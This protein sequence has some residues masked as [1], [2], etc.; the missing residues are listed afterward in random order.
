MADDTDGAG[1]VE[2]YASVRMRL[3]TTA[4]AMRRASE[5]AARRDVSA[6]E[7]KRPDAD[8]D[9]R[10]LAWTPGLKAPVW[11][12]D[13]AA[14]AP[15]P[16]AS[17]YLAAYK[18][19][20]RQTGA[21]ERK[22]SALAIHI[23]CI[24]SPAWLAEA[25]DPHDAQ[26][27]RVWALWTQARLWAEDAFGKGS[28]IGM[29]MDVDEAGAGVVD[30][31]VSP[32]RDLRLG[33]S[34]TPRP[35]VSVN[36]ALEDL[37]GRQGKKRS[38][39]KAGTILNDSWAEW[40]RQYLSPELRRGRPKTE[41][42]RTNI[43]PAAYRRRMAA[44]DQERERLETEIARARHLMQAMRQYTD[45]ILAWAQAWADFSDEVRAYLPDDLHAPSSHPP[46]RPEVLDETPAEPEGLS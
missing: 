4:Q 35:T 19:M 21:G 6:T 43:A 32:V 27:P 2:H 44:L 33:R 12:A 17:D 13:T 10:A 38:S 20:R 31:I 26:N 29:R 23:I 8:P 18:H 9:R 34:P 1:D 37:A 46:S 36:R 16:P 45:E 30:V 15:L 24:V 28:V 14:G 7:A 3:L 42:G 40:A 22:G 11:I 5:H 41:T 25:G 39:F